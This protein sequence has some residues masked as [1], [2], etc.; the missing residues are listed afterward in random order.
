M[1]PIAASIDANE[2][3]AASPVHKHAMP[4]SPPADLFLIDADPNDL[5][6]RSLESNRQLRGQRLVAS[7]YAR[8]QRLGFDVA[9]PDLLIVRPV[10]L[11]EQSLDAVGGFGEPVHR[12]VLIL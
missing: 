7:Q 8:G 5:T 2:S 1:R 9:V 11:A 4:A 3:G 10:P 12:G 6:T